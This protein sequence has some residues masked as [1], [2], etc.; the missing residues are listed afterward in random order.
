MSIIK[1]DYKDGVKILYLKKIFTDE[2]IEKYKNK[3]IQSNLINYIVRED[4]DAYDENNN[5][6]FCFRKNKLSSSNIR[7]F[8]DNVID[9]AKNTTNNRGTG[10]GSKNKNI[11]DNPKIMTNILGYFDRLSPNQKYLLKKNGINVNG[12]EVR[13]TRFNSLYPDKFN[14]CIPLIKEID[15]HYSKYAPEKY[16]LQKKKALQTPFHILG[17]AFTTITVNVN[18]KTTIHKDKGDDPEGYGNLVVIENGEYEGGETCFPQYGCGVDVRTGD[19]L[20]M[21][22]HQ[23]H[24][25]LPIIKKEKEAIRLSIV[26]YLR[27]NIWKKTRGMTHKNMMTQLNKLRKIS[28]KSQNVYKTRKLRK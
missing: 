8:Y 18:F 10:S 5:M 16:R 15:E 28:I 25:N 27:Y 14:K 9:Y 1:E 12:L 24:G 19:V 4:V 3:Q 2:E 22:V 23:Y 7:L 6:L 20:L 21:D 13:E 11:V 26:S 17:T